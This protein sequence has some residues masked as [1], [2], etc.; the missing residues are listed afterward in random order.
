MAQRPRTNQR[1]EQ[2]MVRLR[3]GWVRAFASLGASLLV[4]GLIGCGKATPNPAGGDS[5]GAT[6]LAQINT[7]LGN[8]TQAVRKYAVEKQRAPKNLEEVQAG[9]Y[10]SQIPSAPQGKRFV[11][12]RNLQVILK[13]L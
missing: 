4:V 1:V 2:G 3:P 12:D 5:A 7:T 8:L 6:D 13:D 9:G 10:L 11:I